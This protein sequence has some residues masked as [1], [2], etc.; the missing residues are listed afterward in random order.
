MSQQRVARMIAAHQ[1]AMVRQDYP[2]THA[3]I[4]DVLR[5]LAVAAI[6]EGQALRM[7]A[8]TRA[9]IDDPAR[10]ALSRQASEA[11]RQRQADEHEPRRADASRLVQRRAGGPDRGNGAADAR[12]TRTWASADSSLTGLRLFP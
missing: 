7:L 6:T 3:T 11:W 1:A 2:G 8:I 5:N 12:R 4:C 9:R 10:Q